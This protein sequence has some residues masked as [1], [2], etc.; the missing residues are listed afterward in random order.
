MAQ[1]TQQID[2]ILGGVSTQ[3]DNK[4]PENTVT[5]AVNVYP[6]VSFGLIKRAGLKYQLALEDVPKL[7]DGKW[8][9]VLRNNAEL[10][11]G[12]IIGDTIRVWNP[13][14]GNEA[15]VTFE[16][17][18]KSYLTGARPEDYHVLT[19]QDTSII[20]NKTF[21]T[22][23]Q[24]EA[25]YN[26]DAQ[27][28]IIIKSV[29][30]ATKYN[31]TINGSTYTYTTR[32][33]DEAASTNKLSASEILS[34]LKSGIEGKD[35]GITV[36]QLP[37]SLELTKGSTFSLEANGGINGDSLEYY[38]DEIQDISQLARQSIQNRWVK[39]AGISGPSDD[40]YRSFKASNGTKGQGVW[41]ESRGPGASPGL[42]NATM[43]HELISTGIDKFTFKE[44]SYEPRLVGDAL[45]NPTPSFVGYTIQQS[46]FE[47][48]RFGFLS[49]DNVILSQT[50]D[51]YNFYAVSAL[52]VSAADPVD[53]SVSSIRPTK[54]TA[55]LPVPQGLVLFS[56]NQQFLMY[57]EDS[58]LSP[59]TANVRTLSN[60]EID[61]DID[62]VDLGTY[63]VFLSKASS[64]S[65]L[66]AMVTNG[67]Q[68]QPTVGE[69][70]KPVTEWISADVTD[71]VSDPQS[72]LILTFDRNNNRMYNYR[73]FN[74]GTDD[75]M[76]AWFNWDLPGNPQ[77]V[78]VYNN[79][80][81]MI[82][83][84]S[85][86]YILGS[87]DLN[88][89]A[90]SQ[91][92][93]SSTG[94]YSN[95]AIDLY[96]TPTDVTYNADTRESKVYLP[97]KDDSS[98][99]PIVMIASTDLLTYQANTEATPGWF[100][101]VSS[102]ER[103][104]DN[105]GDYYVIKNEDL[106]GNIDRIVVGYSY[107]YEI[108]LPEVF[109]RNSKLDNVDFTAK[110]TVARMKFSLGLT[111]AV[112]FKL[113]NKG[114]DT[115]NT[116][117]PVTYASYYKA[118][119]GPLSNRELMTLPINQRSSNFR[120]SIQSDFPYPVNLNAYTWEGKYNPMYYKRS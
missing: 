67:E 11:F 53:L 68:N 22:E 25:T 98:L 26:K 13:V 63:L 94:A 104:T 45:S 72:D 109:Y 47:S 37:Y 103:K 101:R 100:Y 33:E 4:K 87:I 93:A 51:Y 74:N 34:N 70:S 88:T 96:T 32:K 48:N 91:V 29:Q 82:I 30:Y 107:M 66:F 52:T 111:G 69:I 80:C 7:K 9:T 79:S 6:D 54:L 84:G 78:A 102:D 23:E 14:S 73:R 90:F 28:T 89:S 86:K 36:T 108:E 10:Y 116:V 40:Y 55:A 24:A 16:G 19:I 50:S 120:V 27:G 114:T 57:S 42:V 46:F 115:W 110:L 18:S 8:F 64:H 59:E 62:P 92:I 75:V 85:D 49:E 38:Q 83:E 1:V 17:S 118:D 112:E 20:T 12:V 15:D 99:K 65:L 81:Y 44:I 56:R 105:T 3:P 43:P 113:Q 60:Y 97:Y 41:T 21:V 106:T 39:I 76:Q 61:P 117:M 31:V 77:A 5:S 2:D 119:T 35:S 58:I 95:P 71:L